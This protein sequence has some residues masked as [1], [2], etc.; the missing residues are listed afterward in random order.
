MANM[1]SGKSEKQIPRNL[2]ECAQPDTTASNLHY[3]SE[4]LENWGQRLFVILIIIGVFSTIAVMFN[5]SDIDDGEGFMI[6]ITTAVT[7]GLYA[8]IEYCAYHVLALLISALASITQNTIIAANVA[9]YNASIN[10]TEPTATSI[11]PEAT[12]SVANMSTP[13]KTTAQK[14]TAEYGTW[15]CKNCGTNNKDSYFQCKKCG[16]YKN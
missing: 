1:F 9:L 2:D 16:Q 14:E 7:W 10:Q 3:W 11:V 13:L 4:R 5:M 8:F 15:V 6:C 12:P